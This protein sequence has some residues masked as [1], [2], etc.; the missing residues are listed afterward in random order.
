VP[1]TR[2]EVRQLLWKRLGECWSCTS[3]GEDEFIVGDTFV[4]LVHRPSLADEATVDRTMSF[5][6]LFCA[7][8]GA[9]TLH[10][11][12]VVDGSMDEAISF[13]RGED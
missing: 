2:D 7:H 9:T 6:P 12:A 13:A 8:C 4:E 1:L 5:L 3:C 11:V 10:A